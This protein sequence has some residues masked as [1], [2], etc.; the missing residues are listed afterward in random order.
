MSASITSMLSVEHLRLLLAFLLGSLLG[1]ERQIVTIHDEERRELRPG[2][3]TFGLLSLLSCLLTLLYTKGHWWAMILSMIAFASILLFYCYSKFSLFR[4]PGIT[5]PVVIALAYAIGALVA[6]GELVLA[7]GLTVFVAFILSS[8]QRIERLLM[9]LHY[10]ELRSAFEIGL[11][12]FFFLPL[13]PPVTD[14]IF[15][16]VN[17]QTFYVFLVI[18]LGLS[19][20]AYVA[21]RCL[22]PQRGIMAFAAVG[23]LVHSE[24]TT[25][26]LIS[27]LKRHDSPERYRSLVENAVL[28]ANSVMILRTI[29]LVG[30]LV[31][32]TPLFERLFIALFPAAAAGI[33]VSQLRSR[34]SSSQ[35]QVRLKIENP[36]S[37]GSA[38]KFTAVFATIVFTVVALQRA[39][40]NIGFLAGCALGGLV[41]NLGVAL[42]AVTLYINGD[43]PMQL[44]LLGICLSTMA[45]TANKVI[46][47]RLAG[48]RGSLIARIGLGIVFLIAIMTPLTLAVVGGDFF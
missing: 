24:A 36:L 23:S 4:E 35:L 10:E 34:A 42:S 20:V 46:W 9:A 19:F 11:L 27:F 17:L 28:L 8:K 31:W 18:V 15:H 45:A 6:L 44:A 16:V 38:I 48:A 26:N 40:S 30:I 12:L 14:P 37:W 39:L 1:L 25:G 41:S 21:V 13:I 43:I 5:T 33:A 2:V 22:G 29:I 3:R 32:G 47:A 7:I